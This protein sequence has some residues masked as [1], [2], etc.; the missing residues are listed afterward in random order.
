MTAL[1]RKDY[2]TFEDWMSWDED[3][4]AEI[5]DGKLYMMAQPTLRHQEVAGDIFWQI[6][7]YLKGKRCKVFYSPIGVRLEKNKDTCLEPDVVVVCDRSKLDGGKICIGPPDMVVEVLSPSTKNK[8]MELKWKKYQEAGVQEYWIVDPDYRY[9]TVNILDKG[10]Y[11]SLQYIA[12]DTISVSVLDGCEVN[13]QSVFDLDGNIIHYAESR[14]LPRYSLFDKAHSLSHVR[15][16]IQNSLEIAADYPVDLNMVY[17]VAAYLIADA[18]ND[19]DYIRVLTRCLQYGLAK[20]PQ[21]GK[22]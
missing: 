15:Q 2:Y 4:R 10:Q 6:Y 8:D 11:K 3:F 18:D 16:V 12:G 17:V 9:I 20:Y 1:Q 5:I 14:I 13:L 7:S 19:L 21:E 22:I